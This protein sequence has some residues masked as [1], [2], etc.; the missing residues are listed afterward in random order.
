MLLHFSCSSF[1]K[2][3]ENEKRKQKITTFHS[4]LSMVRSPS[5][6]MTLEKGEKSHES[7]KITIFSPLLAGKRKMV[8]VLCCSFFVS[9]VCGFIGSPDKRVLMLGE[10]LRFFRLRA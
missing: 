1:P 7:G 9:V 3:R 6:D 2:A 10:G 5:I 4:P 8:F